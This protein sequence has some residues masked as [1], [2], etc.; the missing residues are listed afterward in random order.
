MQILGHLGFDAA[1]VVFKNFSL[2][3]KFALDLVTL[4]AL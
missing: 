1:V 2:L 3:F 4:R